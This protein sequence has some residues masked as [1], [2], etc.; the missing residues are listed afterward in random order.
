[1]RAFRRIAMFD[2]NPE[3]ISM[4]LSRAVLCTILRTGLELTAVT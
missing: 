2:G 4:P 3:L 1:M